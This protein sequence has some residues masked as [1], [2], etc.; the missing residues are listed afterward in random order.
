MAQFYQDLL[1]GKTQF[2]KVAEF[3]SFPSLKYLGLPVTLDDSSADE[4][5]TVYDHPTVMIFANTQSK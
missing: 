1:A 5:F 2:K 4:T 3:T